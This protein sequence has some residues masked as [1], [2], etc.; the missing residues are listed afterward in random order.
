M[1]GPD[2]QLPERDA[3]LLAALRHAP[4]ADI[5][6][7]V[8]LS[9][10]IVRAARV[11]TRAQ[12]KA[13]PAPAPSW[14]DVLA[15]AWLAFSRPPVMAGVASIVLATA[16]GLNVWQQPAEAPVAPPA[17]A[18]VTGVA[19]RAPAPTEASAPALT[20]TARSTARTAAAAPAGVARETPSLAPAAPAGTVVA[21]AAISR[22]DPTAR[23]AAQ[24]T[25]HA[26]AQA[27]NAS[28]PPMVA[29]MHAAAPPAPH[30]AE[31]PSLE[32]RALERGQPDLLA[33]AVPAGKGAAAAK[34]AAATPLAGTRIAPHAADKSVDQ[35]RAERSSTAPARSAAPTLSALAEALAAEPQ[36]WQVRRGAQPPQATSPSA[37]AWLVQLDALAAGRWQSTDV[38][39]VEALRGTVGAEPAS[40][41]LGWERDGVVLQRLWLSADGV[42]WQPVADSGTEGP[43]RLWLPLDE[44]VAL[45]LRASLAAALR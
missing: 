37:A 32:Q 7:P 3:H 22:E 31:S 11:A 2:E 29:A 19:D 26:Q 21:E 14:L 9:N 16:V 5:C 24:T 33:G 27:R 41:D 25:S 44:N 12:A 8:A 23:G 43:R 15:Q 4:D 30:L 34:A 1:S 40:I 18:K 17:K 20:S 10:A 6:A 39:P 45:R 42:L 35:A 13:A 36:R 38:P 28:P